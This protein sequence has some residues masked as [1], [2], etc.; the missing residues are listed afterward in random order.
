MKSRTRIRTR[1][2]RFGFTAQVREE[3]AGFRYRLSCPL[4]HPGVAEGRKKRW[5]VRRFW[6]SNADHLTP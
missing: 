4:G 5:L 1:T 2:P 6:G 3:Q